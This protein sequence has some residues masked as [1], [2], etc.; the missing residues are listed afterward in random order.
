[1]AAENRISLELDYNDL[2][3]ESGE[4]Q[5]AFLLPDAPVQVL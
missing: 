1:M 3:H 5:I 4:P 2:A